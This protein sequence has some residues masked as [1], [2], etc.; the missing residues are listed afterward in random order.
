[1]K[2]KIIFVTS[3]W[4]DRP[5]DPAYY[6]EDCRISSANDRF[7]LR[8]FSFNINWVWYFWTD[9]VLI[10]FFTDCNDSLNTEDCAEC[11]ERLEMLNTNIKGSS[12]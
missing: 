9:P 8:S 6:I 2:K 12:K 11:K 7:Q 4:D 10:L 5:I 3:E 1:M